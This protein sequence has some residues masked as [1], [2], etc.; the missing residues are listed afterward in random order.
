MITDKNYD[1]EK[2]TY[3]YTLD[4]G[5]K[6]NHKSLDKYFEPAY[7]KTAYGVQGK[8]IKSYHYA[9]EDKNFLKNNNRLSYTIISRLKTL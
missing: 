4:F 9:V 3:I 1:V 2:K 6:L 5:I 7:A 8:S